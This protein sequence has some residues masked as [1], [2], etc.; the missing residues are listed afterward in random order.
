MAFSYT[1]YTGNGSTTQY[2]VS[3]PYIRREHVAVTV[4]GIPSTFTWVNNSLIQMDAAPAAAAAVR[5]YRT[6]PISAPLVDFADGATLVAADLDTNSRQSIYIQQ[7]L[8]DAQTDNLPNLIPNGNK[9]EITTSVGGTVW[10]INNGAVTEVKLAANAVTSAK[11]L[12]GTIVNA[13]VNASAGIVATK[14]AFTQAGTGATAR[15]VDSKLKDV[16]SVKDFGATGNNS[17][18][19]TAA[20][21]A[22]INAAEAQALSYGI[23]AFQ[24]APLRSVSIGTQPVVYFPKGT[25]RI[26]SALTYGSYTKFSGEAAIIYQTNPANDIFYSTSIYQNEWSGLVLIGGRTQIHA[27]NG[28]SSGIEGA[29]IKIRSCEFQASANYA[30]RFVKPI[31]A[32]GEQG[33]VKDS[34]FFNCSQDLYTRFD[35][36]SVK[37]CWLEKDDTQAT[38]NQAWI[39]A[40]QLIF[41]DNALI[42]GGNFASGTV[43]YVDNYGSV[44]LE[45][46]RFG[47]E[48]GGGLPI[49]Y[50]FT[51]ALTSGAVYPYMDGGSVVIAN[52]VSLASGNA[53]RTDEAIIVLK[54]G[55]PKLIAIENNGYGFDS[56]CIRTNLLTSGASFS[57]YFAGYQIEQPMLSIRIKNNTKWGGS[58]TDSPSSTNT[59]RNWLDCDLSIPT[60]KI[61]SLP[62]IEGVQ[63]VSFPLTSTSGTT[64]ITDTG[65]TPASLINS[66]TGQTTVFLVHI[67]GNPNLGGNANYRLPFTGLL[68][69]WSD[70]TYALPSPQ[71]S[72]RIELTTLA[73]PPG[74]NIGPLTFS[75]V[76]WDGTTEANVCPYGSAINQIRFK[77]GGYGGATGTYQTVRMMKIAG[78]MPMT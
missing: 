65:I 60:R 66:V 57:T 47:S 73:A 48:G 31:G 38:P 8:D 61:L 18:D 49:V 21:Q 41:A 63:G 9:G 19:D 37:D 4:A 39:N 1:T 67:E 42:P 64:G 76:F 68:T 59:L 74:D 14:L 33:I 70:Y 11:I 58:I 23:D 45:R 20:I 46:N 44:I 30:I 69:F 16:V 34:R 50:N 52:N 2:A 22:A 56:P 10:A 7:E 28:V 24:G 25:Y 51:N 54:S 15:T 72:N 71:P 27:Q 78:L 43:R 36:C 29:L 35:F 32:G 62:P 77:V 55:I 40:G 17:T 13:D 53:G 3:F 5:V 12:D 26:S 75:A 6:T